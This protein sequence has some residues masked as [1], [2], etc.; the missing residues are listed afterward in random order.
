[1]E[2]NKTPFIRNIPFAVFLLLFG[3]FILSAQGCKEKADAPP[4]QEQKAE[5]KPSTA[6][7]VTPKS[8]GDANTAK[9]DAEAKPQTAENVTPKSEGDANTAKPETE[10]KPQT[11]E[12]V[13]SVSKTDFAALEKSVLDIK[14][15]QEANDASLSTFQ[16]WQ[17]VS[18]ISAALIAFL[19]LGAFVLLL[20]KQLKLSLF[21]GDISKSDGNLRKE[22]SLVEKSGSGA[23]TG[24]SSVEL[25]ALKKGLNDLQSQI[26]QLT[27]KVNSQSKSVTRLENDL[28]SF[29]SETSDLKQKLR[30]SED[31]FSSLKTDMDKNREKLAWKEQVEN[32]PVAAFNQWAQ[33]PH[34]PFPQYFTYITSLK[35]EFRTKQDF[36][37]TNTE[38]D[39]IRNTIGDKKY[40]FPNPNKIDRLSGPADKLYKMTGVRKAKGTNSVKVT[41]ACLIKEGNFIEYQGELMLM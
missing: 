38:T 6:E 15:K 41:S 31:A 37:D 5:T 1:M 28:S 17:M 19:L 7:N 34:R 33:N 2:K 23:S 9:P 18:A 27:D 24:A 21:I 36:T 29:Q 20:L 25:S 40:L 10:A 35:L 39:W 8:E 4:K 26:E 16:I 3:A 30:I 22:H 11:A 14:Q 12:N 13:T 32:N